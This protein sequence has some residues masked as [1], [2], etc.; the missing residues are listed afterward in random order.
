MNDS[1][2]AHRKMVGL[3]MIVTVMAAAC[4]AAGA[5]A[6]STTLDSEAAEPSAIELG[7]AMVAAFDGHDADAAVALLATNPS[8]G[9]FRTS[10]LEEFR[11]LFEWFEVV[12]WRFASEGCSSSGTSTVRCSVLQSNTWSE[13]VGADPV[14][15]EL[16]LSVSGRGVTAVEYGFDL[17]TW[18]PVVFEPFFAFVR[19]ANPD[20]V[21]RMWNVTDQGLAGPKLAGE[22]LALF[23]QR[24]AEYA[25]SRA[26]EG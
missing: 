8:I 7:E 20:D 25:A 3:L 22:A 26:D 9:V 10:T 2:S 17:S 4:S 6:P 12:D 15:G 1:R 18:S 5:A 21:F 11:A 16:R 13:A 24:S 23:E 14:S 19:D